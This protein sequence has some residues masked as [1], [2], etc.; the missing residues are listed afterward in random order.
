MDAEITENVLDYMINNLWE[1]E[2]ILR[3]IQN[4]TIKVPDQSNMNE[5]SYQLAESLACLLVA[6]K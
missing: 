1:M 6:T 5:A 2:A 3:D 4:N